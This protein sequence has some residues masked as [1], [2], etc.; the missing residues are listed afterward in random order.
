MHQTH[1]AG[2]KLLIAFT[3]RSRRPHRQAPPS[4]DVRH[5]TGAL[6]FTYAKTVLGRK[7]PDQIAA[8][9]CPLTLL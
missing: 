9:V 8:H 4:A 7:L 6:S 3:G 2:A 1:I 5:H